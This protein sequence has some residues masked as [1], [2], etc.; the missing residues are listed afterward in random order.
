MKDMKDVVE[1]RAGIWLNGLR[2]ASGIAV[3]VQRKKL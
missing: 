3:K 2:L 1:V